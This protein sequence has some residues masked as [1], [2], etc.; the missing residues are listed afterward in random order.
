[1][2][3]A[4]PSSSFSPDKRQFLLS[5]LDEIIK[6]WSH[7]VGKGSFYFTVNDGVPNLQTGL[8]VGLEDDT[9]QETPHP[10]Q[11]CPEPH[12]QGFQDPRIR[13]AKRRR[14]PAQMAKNRARAAAHQARLKAVSANCSPA[15][16]EADSASS[17]VA[18]L[19][20][21]VKLPFSGNM[22]P[23]KKNPRAVSS[24]QR[25]P[26]V[27][28]TSSSPPPPSTPSSYA[29]VVSAVPPPVK[30]VGTELSLTNISSAKKNLFPVFPVNNCPIM[31]SSQ[32]L[33][34]TFKKKENEMYDKIFS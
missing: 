21:T 28:S 16:L 1:M 8:E 26:S 13:T 2:M 19:P 5:K 11:L 3:D 20:V 33:R 17:L 23:L 6:V 24:S 7:G 10:R 4:S 9:R 34:G 31:P 22:L 30:K 25:Q 18:S 12:Y 29:A 15:T 27:A 14:G 32:C